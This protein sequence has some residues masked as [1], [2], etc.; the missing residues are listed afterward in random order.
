MPM[1]SPESAGNIR[2]RKCLCKGVFRGQRLTSSLKGN[3]RN[4]RDPLATAEWSQRASGCEGRPE[5]LDD[6]GQGES[7]FLIVVMKPAKEEVLS[8]RVERRGEPCRELEGGNDEPYTEME[9]HLPETYSSAGES[10]NQSTGEIHQPCASN[11]ERSSKA[12]LP[13]A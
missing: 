7:D 10:E 11:N 13:S 3:T 9:T 1:T 12:F 6:K 5:Y 4:R 2:C 8:E